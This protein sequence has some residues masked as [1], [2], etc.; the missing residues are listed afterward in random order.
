MPTHRSP[1]LHCNIKNLFKRA[2][3]TRM[4][5]ASQA[6]ASRF[7]KKRTPSRG[8]GLEEPEDVAAAVGL[9][10]HLRADLGDLVEVDVD[11][12]E[13]GRRV[14]PAVADDLAPGVDGQRVACDGERP[15]AT[16]YETRSADA[17]RAP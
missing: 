4:G 14:G 11:R 3:G 5:G 10:G 7:R 6:R 16:P 1:L 2:V 8:V 13:R 12:D 17:G 15:R 9:D